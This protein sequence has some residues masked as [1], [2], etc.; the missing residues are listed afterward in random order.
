MTHPVIAVY[1]R[2][3]NGTW[4]LAGHADLE[5]PR[6]LSA[7]QDLR[8]AIESDPEVSRGVAHLSWLEDDGPRS[9]LID[10]IRVGPIES[11][12]GSPEGVGLELSRASDAPSRHLPPGPGHDGFWCVLFSWASF[13]GGG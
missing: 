4:R 1:A 10:I 6:L 2:T 7:H 11:W 8:E 3:A 9:E 12:Q 13:C 5:L